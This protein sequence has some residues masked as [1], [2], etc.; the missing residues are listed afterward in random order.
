MADGTRRALVIFSDGEDSASVHG[1]AQTIRAA[2]L[3][4]VLVFAIRYTEVPKGGL[5]VYNHEGIEAMARLAAD[6]RKS[7]LR[8]AAV[9]RATLSMRR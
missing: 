4:D 8:S 9:N 7:S 6:S 1:L 2:Q 3:K 5:R